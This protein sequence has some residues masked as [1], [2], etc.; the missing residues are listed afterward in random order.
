[1]LL[2][3]AAFTTKVCRISKRAGT[4]FFPR[5]LE[6]GFVRRCFKPVLML[7]LMTPTPAA[8]NGLSGSWTAII[9]EF[10]HQAYSWHFKT[11]RTYQ[12]TGRDLAS[13]R[14]VQPTLSGHWRKEGSHLLLLQDGIDYRFD[15][16]MAD[17]LYSGMLYLDGRPFSRFC[18]IRRSRSH[19]M[20]FRLVSRFRHSPWYRYRLPGRTSKPNDTGNQ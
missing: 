10:P 2:E 7:L 12:E 11:D 19:H 4:A 18:A 14:K 15:G 20:Q 13:G 8:T 6:M 5:L 1:M 17:G 3:G 16:V 9:E